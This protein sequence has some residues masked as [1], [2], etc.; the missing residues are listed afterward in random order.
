M[1]L[2]VA[3]RIR[4]IDMLSGPAQKVGGSIRG[5]D[6]A[7]RSLNGVRA[8]SRLQG[9]LA[10]IGMT[11]SSAD[12]S[13]MLLA[14]RLAGPAALAIGL[15]QSYASFA[16]F[17]DRLATIGITAETSGA[18]L[19]KVGDNAKTIA[20]EVAV[21]GS[22][23]L[24]ATEKLVAGGLDLG[25]AEAITRPVAR[26]AKAFRAELEDVASSGIA[27]MK[28]LKI[29]SGGVAQAFDTM[30]KGGSVGMFELKDM[31]RELP[32]LAAAYNKLGGAGQDAVR[33][34]VALLEIHRDAAGSSAEAAND[35]LNLFQK[36]KANETIEGFK[37]LGVDSEAAFKKA[38]QE[39]R[40]V[41]DVVNELLMKATGGDA[42]KLAKLLPDSQANKAAWSLLKSTISGTLR[43]VRSELDKAGGT[44]DR[45]FTQRMESAAAKTER[46]SAAFDELKISVGAFADSAGMTKMLE[47]I[48]YGAQRAA[49]LISK[50]E[51]RER[52]NAIRIDTNR[53]STKQGELRGSEEKIARFEAMVARDNWGEQEAPGVD[54]AKPCAVPVRARAD[55]PGDRSPETAV[56]AA[57]AGRSVASGKDAGERPSSAA[58]YAESAAAVR[59][60]GVSAGSAAGPAR[61]GCRG[62]ARDAGRDVGNPDRGAERGIR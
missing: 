62:Q 20:R 14:T 24:G 31:A 51:E 57:G 35:V 10:R 42:A 26:T 6:R 1:S 53:I 48:A 56:S 60:H 47:G 11:A 4:L 58:A 21:A 3:L 43:D 16:T 7:A 34:L 55:P 2:D 36:M 18:R 19:R 22:E 38:E 59:E 37:K 5:I 50:P 12:R 17:D 49:D 27:V 41:L 15:K 13:L 52:T 44:V 33:D 23:V 45:A 9:D 39:G 32:P 29:E 28:N 25:S 40:N 61:N 46:L 8:G 54:G 30:A